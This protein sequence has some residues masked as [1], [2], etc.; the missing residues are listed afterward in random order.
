[1]T[2]QR[3]LLILPRSQYLLYG[4]KE[5]QAERERLA[6]EGGHVSKEIPADLANFDPA[7]YQ[8]ALAKRAADQYEVSGSWE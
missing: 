8:E 4:G 1:M 6:I 5:P 2:G 7:A 3:I